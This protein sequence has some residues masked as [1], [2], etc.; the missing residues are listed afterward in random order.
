MDNTT[1]LLAIDAT[2]YANLKP[3]SFDIGGVRLDLTPNAQIWPR[4]LNTLIGGN[5]SA[6]YLIIADLELTPG[7][8]IDLIN[9]YTFLCV[10]PLSD[11]ERSLMAAAL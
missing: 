1:G 3:L 8:T 11:P 9:G 5:A 4:S 10:P 6:I 2:Q 7:S